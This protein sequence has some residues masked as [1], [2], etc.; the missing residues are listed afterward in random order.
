MNSDFRRVGLAPNLVHRRGSG[1]YDGPT[2]RVE[3]GISPREPA[4]SLFDPNAAISTRCLKVVQIIPIVNP[5]HIVESVQA[6]ISTCTCPEK[7]T[8]RVGESK[9]VV[10]A[11]TIGLVTLGSTK[12]TS[13]CF[14]LPP[15]PP[16]P[17]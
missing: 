10:S 13:L 4:S 3:E 12:A 14:T 15:K 16:R 7:R 1:Q 6:G 2:R 11:Q 17:A 5:K 9:E 8:D